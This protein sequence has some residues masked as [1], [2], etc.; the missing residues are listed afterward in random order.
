[1]FDTG[2]RWPLTAAQLGSYYGHEL[3]PTRWG[4]NQASYLE[5][6]GPIRVTEFIA[7]V[8]TAVRETE[9]LHTRCH[10]DTD[11]PAQYLATAAETPVP[12]VDLRSAGTGNGGGVPQRTTASRTTAP[13]LLPPCAGRLAERISFS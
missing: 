11:G 12:V 9:A 13:R 7:A 5:I 8:R 1:M 6:D 10:A 4:Y 3:D 2:E